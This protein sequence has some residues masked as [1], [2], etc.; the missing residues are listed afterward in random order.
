MKGAT[1]GENLD[2]N[3][4]AANGGVLSLFDG[5]K[6]YA[7]LKLQVDYSIVEHVEHGVIEVIGV[8]LPAMQAGRPPAGAAAASSQPTSRAQSPGPSSGGG[9]GG[10]GSGA[11]SVMSP[12]S[13]MPNIHDPTAPPPV[14]RLYVRSCPARPLVAHAFL[15]SV[16]AL[17]PLSAATH[18]ASPSYLGR[19]VG[20]EAF[21]AKVSADK[22][23]MDR[24]NKR[25][26]Q[27]LPKRSKVMR[28]MVAQSLLGAMSLS[29]IDGD[30]FVLKMPPLDGVQVRPSPFIM[31]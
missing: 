23:A 2:E 27:T 10:G 29:K 12:H 20:A 7:Q 18:L 22:Q 11:A 1:D 6:N 24:K 17:P 28:N 4:L 14:V 9:D 30:V 5:Q 26:E 13:S 15:S 19:Y 25:P 21:Y 3:A 31:G 16:R 8:C